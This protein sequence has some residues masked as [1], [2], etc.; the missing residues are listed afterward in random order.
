MFLIQKLDLLPSQ[1]TIEKN[2]IYFALWLA[3]GTLMGSNLA[4]NGGYHE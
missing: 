2:T 3:I 4:E 1:A